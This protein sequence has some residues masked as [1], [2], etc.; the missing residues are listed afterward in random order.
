MLQKWN[1]DQGD[2]QDISEW[3][4]FRDYY[5]FCSKTIMVNDVAG[6]FGLILPKLTI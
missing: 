5:W 4:E 6:F 3:T 2:T 1:I